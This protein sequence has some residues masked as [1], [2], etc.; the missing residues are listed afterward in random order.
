MINPQSILR[1]RVERKEG[2]WSELRFESKAQSNQAYADWVT[3]VLS[4]PNVSSNVG[5]A[6]IRKA[7]EVSKP[8]FVIRNHDDLELLISL[9]RRNTHLCNI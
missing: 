7:L 4:L 9:K 8:L 2:A 1:M 6:G 3:E 5:K